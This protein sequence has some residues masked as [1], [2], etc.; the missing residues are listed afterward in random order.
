MEKKLESKSLDMEVE[1]K[2][3]F[4]GFLINLFMGMAG[5]YMFIETDIDALFLD[6]N[7]SLISAFG[8]I[9]AILISKYS[10][11]KTKYFPNGLYFLEPLY[12]TLKGLLSLFLIL[13]A[14]DSALVKLYNF[15]FLDVGTMLELENI[16]YYSLLMT[17]LCFL[18]A[19]VFFKYNKKIDD[20]STILST[21]SKSSYVDGII[22]LGLGIAIVLVTFLPKSGNTL[23][24][25]YIGDALLT[26]F[27]VIFTIKT[28]LR[29]LKESFIEVM[30]GVI[31]KG[32]V[33]KDIE[34][35]IA[36]KN[37]NYNNLKIEKI[38][39]HKVG[40]SINVVLKI[41]VVDENKSVSEI[42][43]FK[44]NLFKVLEI[45]FKNISL[46]IVL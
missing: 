30:N 13:V 44:E 10:E 20:R 46:N 39:I 4:I 11:K 41:A 27:L 15:L 16:L 36:Q 24:V 19:G 12:A 40:K 37:D 18:L 22:S 8:C 2:A 9:I 38:N 35:I 23:F 1:S 7:F 33:K 3:L 32:K 45:D 26:I 14:T 17:F 29:A 34:K 21:E 43:E 28:P 5:W 25:Y 31:R 6:G 42:L